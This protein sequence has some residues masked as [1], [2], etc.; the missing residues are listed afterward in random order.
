MLKKLLI[1]ICFIF[2]NQFHFSQSYWK[3]FTYTNSQLLSDSITDMEIDVFGTKYIGTKKGY[4]TISG[5]TWKSFNSFPI[6]QIEIDSKNVAWLVGN[7]GVISGNGNSWTPLN[8]TKSGINDKNIK[9]IA[10]DKNESVW[11]ATF[12]NI[13]VLN[14][15]NWSHYNSTNNLFLNDSINYILND[16][17]NQKW[18]AT[19]NGVVKYDGTNWSRIDINIKDIKLENGKTSLCVEKIY[20][21]K[22]NQIY[23]ITK[24]GI[25]KYDSFNTTLYK[26]NTKSMYDE[27]N[28]TIWLGLNMNAKDDCGLHNLITSTDNFISNLGCSYGFDAQY[29]SALGS[30]C[31][32][33]KRDKTGDLWVATNSGL[34]KNYTNTLNTLET[35]ITISSYKCERDSFQVCIKTNIIQPTFFNYGQSFSKRT[36]QKLTNGECVNIGNNEMQI[37]NGL[38]VFE[39]DF[40]PK[41]INNSPNLKITWPTPQPNY[42]PNICLITNIQNHNTI[43]WEN[44]AE[45]FITKY[46]IYKQSK[47]TS[48]YELISEQD[49]SKLSQWIDTNSN[50]QVERYLLAY[51]DSCGKEHQGLN[52]TTISLSSNLGSNGTVNLAWNAY[53]GFEYPNFEIWRSTNGST[54][55]LLSNV[56]NN[57]LS[58]IDNN[59]PVNGYYQIRITTPNGCNPT[60]RGYSY[61]NSNTVDKTGKTVITAGVD[62]LNQ[63]TYSIFPNPASSKITITSS[64]SLIGKTIKLTTITGNVVKSIVSTK[65]DQLDFDISDLS[66][67]VYLIHIENKASKVVV[68]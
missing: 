60:K 61:V 34:L 53:E 18:I 40:A 31:N 12:N 62:E 50:I 68:E 36:E 19:T 46:R 57:T 10:F 49:K 63:V 27:L 64:N 59:P 16:I 66:K 8:L 56:A 44:T 14:G 41:N 25:V 42:S 55:N 67:G 26:G 32:E 2:L 29:V 54:F 30:G 22:N 38:K 7:G 47:K 13:A 33:I 24:N 4:T 3:T 6:N 21:D 52:H 65:D 15:Q 20:Q 1:F 28:G 45:S 43:I 9:S 17:N 51:V 35:N 58:F 5:K 48:N 37:F 39:G 23:F 11:L